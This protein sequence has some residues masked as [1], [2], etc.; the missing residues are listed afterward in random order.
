[1]SCI[2]FVPIPG[3]TQLQPLSTE[4]VIKELPRC[5]PTNWMAVPSVE[6]DPEEPKHPPRTWLQELWHF[7]TRHC[8]SDL[9]PFEK[10][11]IVPSK[12]SIT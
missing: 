12:V 7:L 9:S 6:W 3:Y 1:M 8:A 11:P 4:A 10:L 5:L 2:M